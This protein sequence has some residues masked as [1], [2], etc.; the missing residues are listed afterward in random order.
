MSRGG[1]KIAAGCAVI[2]W[3]LSALS[4]DV[5]DD[6]NRVQLVWQEILLD[7]YGERVDAH[8]VPAA[9]EASRGVA[10]HFRSDAA[11]EIWN[12]SLWSQLDQQKPVAAASLAGLIL[13]RLQQVEAMEMLA[14]VQRGDIAAAQ[15]WRALLQLPRHVSAVEG[16][17]AL[18]RYAA[19]PSQQSQV[20]QMLAREVLTWQSALIREKLA[21]LQRLIAEH[22]APEVVLAARVAEVEAL[23]AFRLEVLQWAQV[24][25]MP[26]TAQDWIHN[27]VAWRQGIEARLPNLLPPAEVERRERLLLKLLHLVPREYHNGVRAGEVV[28]PLEYREAVTFILQSQ[29]LL[30]E[31]G[32]SWRTSRP[33]AYEQYQVTVQ[34][35]LDQAEKLIRQKAEP[36]EVEAAVKAAVILLQGEYDL[37][38]RRMGAK[39]DVIAESMLDVRTVL[40]NSLLAAQ[41]GRWAEAEAQRLDAYTTF[42]LEIEKRVLPRDPELG[43]RAERSFLDG[44]HQP[45]VKAVLDR[46]L[47]GP[48]LLA[49]YERTLALL[50]ECQAMLAVS[51]SPTTVTFTA[52]T[53]VTREG[54]EA[55]VILAALLAG[56]RGLENR[57][58]RRNIWTGVG[59]SL[60]A[61]AITFWLS[62]TLVQ[63]LMNYGE[64]LEAVISFLA[65]GIL[66]MVTNWVFHKFYWVGWNAKLR[67]LRRAVGEGRQTFW[68]QGAMIGVGFLTIYRE[69]FET[70][71][72]L[73]SLILE[74]GMS[75]VL[76]G[77]G[78]GLGLIGLAGAAIFLVGIKLPYRRLL[79]LTGLLVVGILMTFLGSTVRLFQT[80]GWCPI[81]PITGWEIPNWM[82]LWL[83]LYPSWE[84]LGLP[85]LG[86]VYVGG[87]WAWVRWRSREVL[88]KPALASAEN[89][90]EWLVAP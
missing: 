82:G 78:L 10:R 65:V 60:V 46:R 31:L 61:T 24:T 58:S 18:Q 80:V 19:S 21:Q 50:E 86:F 74:G 34:Q 55:V 12:E 43:L 48:E 62:R 47:R 69:G 68:E 2:L 64:K 36:L 42:D 14:A 25:L 30:N 22:H 85:L 5:L 39:A 73:Q 67:D 79:I 49:A 45:G 89:R 88:V 1:K 29:Q 37:S 9:I 13:G 38:L 84:G 83:G 15:E 76:K 90:A 27:F 3:G 20:V 26:E 41:T 87:A 56:L 17:L 23:A 7:A 71:L 70:T 16:A 8:N 81:H 11:A 28:V 77:T 59:L 72:F 63:S 75:P 44:L 66:L 35:N 52:V 33:Q 6:V 57:R 51:L 53:I 4:A 32:A 40:K 54:L